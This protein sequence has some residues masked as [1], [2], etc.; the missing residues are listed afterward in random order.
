MRFI[1]SNTAS[2]INISTKLQL[3]DETS[4]VFGL[5]I[6]Y[7]ISGSMGNPVESYVNV[8]IAYLC[9]QGR[10][11]S[12]M[13]GTLAILISKL[14]SNSVDEL[15][16]FD[17]N[18]DSDEQNQIQRSVIYE[19]L[20]TME[21]IQIVNY[22]ISYFC[23]II[24]FLSFCSELYSMFYKDLDFTIF[25]L[26]IVLCV[27]IFIIT[28]ITITYQKKKSLT[29]IKQLTNTYKKQNIGSQL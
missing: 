14:I 6:G 23:F 4:V 18:P 25:I 15:Y 9:I 16:S 20:N 1:E 13:L 24:F 11:V 17:I 12:A 7:L 5:F 22:L 3:F 26:I 19:F 10:G 21:Y 2:I 29:I 28:I 27:I 8:P